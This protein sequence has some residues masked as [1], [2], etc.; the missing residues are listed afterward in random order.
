MMRAVL[1]WGLPSRWPKDALLEPLERP[2]TADPTR[3]L[4]AADRGESS[5]AIEHSYPVAEA[6]R[7]APP[8]L[9]ERSR[10]ASAA[11]YAG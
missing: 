9:P 10:L 7:G 4:Q 11:E 6:W 3:L 1:I 5:T 2:D 8:P